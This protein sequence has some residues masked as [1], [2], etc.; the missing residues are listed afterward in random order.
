MAGRAIHYQLAFPPQKRLPC[1]YSSLSPAVSDGSDAIF[2][3]K[4]YGIL[5]GQIG[6]IYGRVLGAG[7]GP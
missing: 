4:E 2:V 1:G 5:K 3:E 6:T 7:K